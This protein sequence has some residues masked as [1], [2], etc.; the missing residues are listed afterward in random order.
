MM[1]TQINLTLNFNKIKEAIENSDLNSAVKASITVLMNSYMED[2]RDLYMKNKSYERDESRQDYRNGYYDRDLLTTVG[3]VKL[4]VPRSRSGEFSTK[5]FEKHQRCD[6]AFIISMIEMVVNGVSTRKVTNVVKELCGENVS[7][8]F[9][10]NLTK[11]LDPIVTEWAA[12]RLNNEVYRYMYVDAMYI[13]VREYHRVVSK[14]VYI[15]L[16]VNSED[17]R[18][19][20]GFQIKGVESHHNWSEF[21]N[22][23]VKRGLVT[24]KLIISDAHSGLKR[25]AKETFLGAGWQRCVVHFLRN[26]MTQ[27]PRKNTVDIRQHIKEIFRAPTEEISRLL[28]KELF[29]VYGN[30]VKYQKALDILDEGYEDAIQYYNEEPATHTHIKTTNSIERLNR[31]IRRRENVIGIFPNEQSAFRLIGAVLMDQEEKMDQ[32]NRRFFYRER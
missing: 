28:K 19:I 18:E 16:G 20:I 5:I 17:R 4:R 24:P 25:A 10:S 29:E 8:S 1:M 30:E 21:F 31:E 27:L 15:A 22:D 12:R 9:V 26:I 32:G 14:A 6:Q 7:K 13:K 2:E 23:L 11:Q 3:K